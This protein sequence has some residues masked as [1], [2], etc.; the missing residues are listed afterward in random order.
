[1]HS[2]QCTSPMGACKIFS[3]I[4]GENRGQKPYKASQ[5]ENQTKDNKGRPTTPGQT[6]S[7]QQLKSTELKQSNTHKTKH[8]QQ[9]KHPEN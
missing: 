1:M 4:R 9:K 7:T 6:E 2:V 3:F 5:N 8:Q